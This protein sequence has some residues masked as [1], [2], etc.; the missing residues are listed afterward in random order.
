MQTAIL[1]DD[2]VV[3]RDGIKALIEETGRLS[4]VG[5][6]SDGEEALILVKEMH[7]DVLITDI[8]MPK[9]SGID[10]IK[11]VQQESPG[12]KILV[13]TM[14]HNEHY[15]MRSMQNGA[16][17]YVLKDADREEI[18][19]AIEAI[20]D[21]KKFYDEKTSQMMMQSFIKNARGDQEPQ[22]NPNLSKRELEVLR[23][24][25]EGH[26]SNQIAEKLFISTRTV[27]SHRTN[28]M[29]KLKVKNT[30]ELVKVSFKMKLL[31]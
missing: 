29:Q 10:L 23:Y 21:G 20:S 19:K 28:I 24:V 31:D 4:I 22:P 15:V 13:L 11:Q 25:V 14:H 1:A 17:G 27:D 16:S 3:V 6:A 30:A 18:Y 26:T 9:L 5:E 8:T 7:P 12:T 2:H